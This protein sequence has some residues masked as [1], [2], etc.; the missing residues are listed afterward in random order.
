MGSG[1][2]VAAAPASRTDQVKSQ[3]KGETERHRDSRSHDPEGGA[4]RR[5]SS[6][7][8]RDSS[9]DAHDVSCEVEGRVDAEDDSG[10][11]LDVH[12]RSL[13]TSSQNGPEST[14]QAPQ[15]DVRVREEAQNLTSRAEGGQKGRRKSRSEAARKTASQEWTPNPNP[16]APDFEPGNVAALVHGA[17]SERA[18]A[19]KAAEVHGELLTLVP[20]LAEEKFLPAVSRYLQA[21][22]REALLHTHITTLS[23]EKGP[24]AV[25]A[26]VW[27][28]AT[29]AA[30]L[31]AKLGSDLG[32]DPIGHARIRALSAGAG[33]AEASLADLAAEG[34]RALA[35]AD[36]RHRVAAE[37]LDD[38][39]DD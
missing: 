36:E 22:A 24:G 17:N 12:P 20:Y 38:T 30:R 39:D 16:K 19:A 8:P 26:R 1:D 32:L 14:S 10:R 3:D 21:A 23:A 4:S 35:D 11:P 5:D 13:G 25:P 33:V 9:S 7:D 15:N 6:N 31:A 2:S 29:A 27:E 28:Q 18:I 34:R 37:A